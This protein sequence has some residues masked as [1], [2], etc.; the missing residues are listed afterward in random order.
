MLADTVHFSSVGEWMAP[1]ELLDWFN[2]GMKIFVEI[3]NRHGGMVNKFTG[4][5]FLAVFGAPC[6]STPI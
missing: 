3:I 5:G 1:T 2:T 6:P 4:D